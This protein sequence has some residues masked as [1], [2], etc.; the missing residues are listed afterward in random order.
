MHS[1]DVSIYL[2]ANGSQIEVAGCL[3]NTCTLRTA[4]ELSP[5]FADLVIVVD[6]QEQRKQ[7]YLFC[8]ISRQ[9]LEIKFRCLPRPGE[10]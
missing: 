2:Q 9:S 6:G 5:C 4:T 1:A 10:R 3:E 7:I 8:G